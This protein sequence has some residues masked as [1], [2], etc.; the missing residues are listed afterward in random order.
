MG[1]LDDQ[2]E[3]FEEEPSIP[4]TIEPERPSDQEI[5]EAIDDTFYNAEDGFDPCRYELNVC[6]IHYF[7]V[8]FQLW[9][10]QQI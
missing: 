8:I 3:D 10:D 2:N 7:L 9:L 6:C 4:E 1:T 5:L